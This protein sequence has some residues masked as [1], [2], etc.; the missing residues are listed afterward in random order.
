MSG[1]ERVKRPT[2]VIAGGLAVLTLG[3]VMLLGGAPTAVAAGATPTAPLPLY[4]TQE[5]SQAQRDAAVQAAAQRVADAMNPAPATPEWLVRFNQLRALAGLAP[6]TENTDWS[7]GCMLHSKYMCYE[8]LTHY[9]DL[10]SPWYTPEGAAAGQSSN[11][12]WGATGVTAIDGWMSAPFHG[13]GMVDPR[14]AVTG[15][16]DYGNCSALDV[17][18]GLGS[19]P[20][21]TVYPIFWP[22]PGSVSPLTQY[23]GAEWPNP[24]TGTPGYTA[25]S[26]LPLIIQFASTPVVTETHF[27]KGTQELQHA[28][29]TETTY[30]NPDPSSQSLGRAVLAGRHAVILIPRYPLEKGATYT[31]E[32]T[33]NGSTHSCTFSTAPRP[34][35]TGL[36]PTNGPIHGGNQVTITGLA[37][38]NAAGVVFGD[39]FLWEDEFT[40]DSPT[41]ITVTAPPQP[42]GTAE[43]VVYT[44]EDYDF[45]DV[46]AASRYL[47]WSPPRWEETDSRL[48]FMGAWEKIYTGSASGG[49]YYS[50]GEPGATVLANFTGTSVWLVGRTTPWYGKALVSLDG[51][52]EEYVD[53]YSWEVAYKQAVYAKT[54]LSDGPH[55]LSI[56]YAGE[57]NPESSYYTIS[58]D[59]IDVIGSLTQAPTP[60]RYHDTDPDLTYTPAWDTVAGDWNYSNGDFSS[61][62]KAGSISVE[63]EGT[64]CAWYGRTTPWYGKAKVVLDAGTPGE[65]ITTV[66]LYSTSIR[67]KQKVYNTGVLEEGTHTLAVYWMG[68]SNPSSAGT[69]IGVDSFDVFGTLTEAEPAPPIEWRYQQSDSRMTYLGG[70]STGSTWSA[71]GGSYA[72]TSQPGA[73]VLATFSGTSVSVLSRTTPWYGKAEI[74]VDDVL[75]DTVDLYSPSTAWKVPIYQD[76]TLSDSEHTLVIKC[77]GTKNIASSGTAVCL[78]ALDIRGYL[79]QAPQTTRIDDNNAGY[80]TYSPAWSRWD[81]SG[82]W[83]AYLD[84]YAFTDQATYKVT[85]TFHGTYLSWV[86]RTANTQGRAK[87]TLDGNDAGTVTVD[88]YSP[89][90]IWKK[91]VYNTGL[92]DDGTHTVVIECLGAKNPAS[93][94]YSIG[95]DAFDVMVT[96]P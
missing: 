33:V 7:Y 22:G 44:R 13:L 81:A 20:P 64:Y 67:Y 87:V 60:T 4:V 31:V 47:Y 8:G 30:T 32:L 26:G 82:Y 14:L 37:F 75:E 53:F 96:T 40:V 79:E 39:R 41:Q 54:G 69:R 45:S 35:V 93:W 25:P 29:F 59:A 74:Y 2:I 21:G 12:F 18:R 43:V 92:L 61:V 56:R 94:W 16:G 85:V 77:L 27:H 57:K 63:F 86:S 52:P 46:T 42:A 10:D 91:S 71:S 90:T 88:L 50:V 72:S 38:D 58:F 95:V 23:W 11:C 28:Y 48:T 15:Y 70:W 36:S 80:A 78:D 19:L 66:G 83:A 24:L 49:S 3:L 62:D 51:G 84:T 68:D 1:S 17:I 34:A 6:V 73:A 76:D 5:Q 55:T 89:T 9:E 65:T